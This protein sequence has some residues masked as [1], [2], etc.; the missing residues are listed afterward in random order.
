MSWHERALL[1]RH[2]MGVYHGHE[3]VR[4]LAD[5]IRFVLGWFPQKAREYILLCSPPS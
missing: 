4:S 3:A 5:Y 2:C 1:F